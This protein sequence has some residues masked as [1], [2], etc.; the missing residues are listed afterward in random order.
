MAAAPR[1]PKR[2]DPALP[3]PGRVMTQDIIT[4]VLIAVLFTGVLAQLIM[5]GPS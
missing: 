4:A 1:R 5:A 3:A 2:A